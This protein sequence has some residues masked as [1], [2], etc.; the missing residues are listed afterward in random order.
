M[1]NSSSVRGFR[2]VVENNNIKNEEPSP[3]LNDVEITVGMIGLLLPEKNTSLGKLHGYVLDTINTIFKVL[4]IKA[5]PY[6]TK[7][8]EIKKTQLENIE[9]VYKKIKVAQKTAGLSE[10]QQLDKALTDLSKGAVRAS[11]DRVDKSL[12]ADAIKDVP[13]FKLA[14]ELM[15][16]KLA[17]RDVQ[18]HSGH[19]ML[20]KNILSQQKYINTENINKNE[21]RAEIYEAILPSSEQIAKRIENLSKFKL[22]SYGS[23]RDFL[24]SI[25]GVIFSRIGYLTE[26]DKLKLNQHEKI[27]SLLLDLRKGKN[28]GMK[29]TE[30]LNTLYKFTLISH[31]D[32]V[33]RVRMDQEIKNDP[34]LGIVKKLMEKEFD[35]ELPYEYFMEMK[36][37]ISDSKYDNQISEQVLRQDLNNTNMR[38]HFQG[39]RKNIQTLNQVE[40][41]ILWTRN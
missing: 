6:L 1:D 39:S 19:M 26:R 18:F 11:G 3:L 9:H 13:N 29:P 16:E 20:L 17:E 32:R 21:L 41:N 23:G 10:K 34:R 38:D 22:E 35:H 25:G 4:S 24:D 30:E 12:I 14:K 31:G 2:Q 37:I 33:D 36:G 27:N 40:D 8:D 5:S 7:R 15:E 28:F